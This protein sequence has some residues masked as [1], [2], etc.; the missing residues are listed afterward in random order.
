MNSAAPLPS[1]LYHP[2]L[3]TFS[4][5]HCS[6]S[7][8]HSPSLSHKQGCCSSILDHRMGKSLFFLSQIKHTKRH[9]KP[10][11]T[12]CYLGEETTGCQSSNQWKSSG[13][14]EMGTTTS[15]SLRPWSHH[16]SQPSFLAL[17]CSKPAHVLC[18]AGAWEAAN[19]RRRSWRKDFPFIP[20]GSFWQKKARE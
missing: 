10:R 7:S 4:S 12:T 9:N 6:H 5:L 1:L 13:R 11:D 18:F 17:H 2:S 15:P 16:G 20:A 8:L 19:P 3:T 14:L